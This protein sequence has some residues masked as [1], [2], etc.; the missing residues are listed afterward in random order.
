MKLT[1][2]P[3]SCT[4]ISHGV[5]IHHASSRRDERLRA[6][7]EADAGDEATFHNRK[8]RKTIPSPWR[9]EGQGGGTGEGGEGRSG[10]VPRSRT[11]H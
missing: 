5:R 3:P 9:T 10:H 6:W 1:R 11:S 7:G 8:R 2:I 4:L